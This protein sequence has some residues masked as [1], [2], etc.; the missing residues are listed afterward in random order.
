LYTDSLNL[1]SK[2]SIRRC[3]IFLCLI[4]LHYILILKVLSNHSIKWTLTQFLET[5][6][7]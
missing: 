5:L 2:N 4:T 7:I 1:H 6:K 3:L